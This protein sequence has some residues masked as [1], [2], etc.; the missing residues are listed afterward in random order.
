MRIVDGALTA[1]RPGILATGARLPE[2]V[3]TN[4]ELAELLDVGPEWIEHRTGVRERRRAAAG[5]ATSDLATDAARTALATAGI[6]ARDV[7]LIVVG[8]STPDMP[9]PATAC[10]VQAN[11]GADGACAMDIGAVCTGFVYAL[12][13]AHKMMR[14]DPAVRYALVVGADT[15]SRVLDYR[16]RGTCVLFGDGAGAVVLG[17][18]AHATRIDY[19]KL[20]SD[21]AKSGYVY[22][23]GGG[24][25]TP[26]STAT[27]AAGDH[28]FKMK[29]KLVREFVS[30]R[31]PA[32]VGDVLDGCD[33][34]LSDIDLIVPH[35]ANGRLLADV[36]KDIGFLPEQLAMTVDRYGNTGAASIP[37][38]LDAAVSAGRVASE[39]RVLLAGVGGGMTWGSALLT[40]GTAAPG[41]A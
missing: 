40:W 29:G 6:R 13:V 2:S 21:G 12:D 30:G 4:E 17:R 31:L 20:G 25:R 36:C 35:Q 24:S 11:L 14:C 27:V 22:I 41:G 38:T 26:S 37:I 23:P 34:T 19:T 10:Q 7:G 32:M 9:L 16:D 28:Y 39:S 8:T 5:E 33:L 15:Y 3:V 18:S 1:A